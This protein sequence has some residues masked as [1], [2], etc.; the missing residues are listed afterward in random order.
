MLDLLK[1][2]AYTGLGLAYM[3]QE[4][5]REVA[6][7][8]SRKAKLSEEEGKRFAEELSAKSKE[9]RN[10][11][12]ERVASAVQKTLAKLNLPTAADLAALGERLTA[13]ENSL[14]TE[15]NEPTTDG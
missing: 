1:K 4:K 9:A 8:L 5:V 10:G 13:V 6:R 3:T 12:E 7:D 11:L 15:A 14:K 2:T